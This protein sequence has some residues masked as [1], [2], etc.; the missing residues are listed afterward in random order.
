[1]T[2]RQLQRHE[3]TV[4]SGAT[5]TEEGSKWARAL[6]E[7]AGLPEERVYALD[8][9]IVEMVGNIVDHSYRGRPG[10]I[11]LELALGRGSAILTVVDDG[12]AF[13]PLSVPAPVAAATLDDAAV[14]G[15]GIHMVR[16][17]ADACEYERRE[18][19]NV[20]TAYFGATSATSAAA[21]ST[22]SSA[23]DS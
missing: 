15:Y 14:G 22:A 5:S 17:S 6:A 19:R 4:R 21:G 2:T 11:R 1:M 8:L 13:D 20:F 3:L 18:G 23:S 12:P 10:E 16:S 9:C 7:Q